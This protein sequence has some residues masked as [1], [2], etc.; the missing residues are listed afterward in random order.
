MS[1]D[2]K[3]EYLEREGDAYFERNFDAQKVHGE[4]IGVKLFYNFILCQVRGGVYAIRDKKV[5]DLRY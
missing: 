3:R 1:C 2:A 4:S 5:L